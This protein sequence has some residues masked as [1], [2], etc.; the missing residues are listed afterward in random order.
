MANTYY[1]QFGG[2][3]PDHMTKQQIGM[4]KPSIY[5]V[6]GIGRDTY[7]SK[8]NGG[9]YFAQRP[10]PAMSVGTFKQKRN[11]ESNLCQIPSKTVGYYIDGTGRDTY[12]G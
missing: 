5:A 1:S 12:I 3:A 11:T 4:A 7:I 6:D 8:D 10:A 2:T 9:F